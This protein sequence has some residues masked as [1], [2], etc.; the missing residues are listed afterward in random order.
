MSEEQMTQELIPFD[1]NSY[2][3]EYH[4]VWIV[5]TSP[6]S[7]SIKVD[8]IR[9]IGNLFV[10]EFKDYEGQKKK[11]SIINAT[12][13]KG[14]I[15]F[16][17]NDGIIFDCLIKIGVKENII[18]QNV[19]GELTEENFVNRSDFKEKLSI[20]LSDL[21][22]N[23]IKKNRKYGNSALE[24]IRVFSKSATDEQL[25]VRMDDK[26]SRIKNRQHDEDEEPE[27]DLAGYLILK[28]VW[29]RYYKK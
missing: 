11:E 17:L 26:L 27:F 12:L 29:R 16:M 18:L 15:H 1:W 24:P 13:T 10:L 14:K 22:K 19:F 9:L 25:N 2:N 8:S 28:E 5:P 7:K 6:E 20:V 3:P 4:D 21:E 23:L